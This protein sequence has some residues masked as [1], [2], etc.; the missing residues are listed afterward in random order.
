MTKTLLILRH[1]KSS[2]KNEKLKDIDRPLKHRGEQDAVVIG[3]VLTM[4]ELIPQVI[5]SSPAQRAKQTAEL[6]SAESKFKGEL[7]FVNSFYMGEPENYIKALNELP[8]E[9]ERVMV[10]GHNPGLEA[11]LQLL[12]GKVDS[13][14]TGSLAYLVLGIKHWTEL[15]KATVGELISFWEPDEI[16]LEEM[17]VKMGKDKD[18]K[19]KKDKKE[20]KEK[21]DKKK[22]KK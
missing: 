19:D 3:K 1:A 9:I 16:N 18:K 12:D 13:L 21:K 15:T 8:D 6:V 5:L 11:L 17:E 22:D 4:T 14:P 20:K 7:K 10:V 2:W